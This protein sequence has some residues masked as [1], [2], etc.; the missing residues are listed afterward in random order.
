MSV[1]INKPVVHINKNAFLFHEQPFVRL[2]HSQLCTF[3]LKKEGRAIAQ[4]FFEEKERALVSLPY[5]PFGGVD[6]SNNL[7]LPEIEVLVEKF[8]TYAHD[9][10][11]INRIS[12][13][14][15]PSIYRPAVHQII[16]TTL[17]QFKMNKT[18]VSTIQYLPVSNDSFRSLTSA[19]KKRYLNKSIF[20]FKQLSLDQ[21]QKVFDFIKSG[22][23]HKQYELSITYK[24]I[25][26]MSEA[27][28]ERIKLFGLFKEKKLAAASIS[29][30]VNSDI[31]YDFHH[32][33]SP[34]FSKYAPTVQLLKGMYEYCQ[35]NNFSYLDLGGSMLNAELN[36][37]LYDFKKSLGAHENDKITYERLF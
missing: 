5:A 29:I 13:T 30:I 8:I 2:R 11:D 17:Q 21:L 20:S 26:Q 4:I 14:H 9:H 1:E 22:R 6:S 3:T 19:D 15:Y 12:I 36:K 23:L 16:A 31:L 24:E 18:F 27:F 7:S 37:G 28:P 25:Q 35:N 33:D 10:N 34:Q 32:A